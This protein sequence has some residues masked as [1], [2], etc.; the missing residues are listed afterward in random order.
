QRSRAEAVHVLR[1]CCGAAGVAG[2]RRPDR[3]QVPA[4]R[5]GRHVA[6]SPERRRGVKIHDV[7]QRTPEWHALR[8]RL[9]TASECGVF[10]AEE[11][12]CRLSISDIKGIIGDKA[13][14]AKATA[15]EWQA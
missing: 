15:V 5:Q 10:L 3:R 2:R 13:L 14:P 11:K 6:G 9:F 12:Q 7:E 4:G 1:E 8:S